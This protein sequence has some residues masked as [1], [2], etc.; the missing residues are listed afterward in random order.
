MKDIK[1]STIKKAYGGLLIGF[2]TVYSFIYYFA[3]A[4]VVN[5]YKEIGVTTLPTLVN[6]AL[7]FRIGIVAIVLISFAALGGL[8]IRSQKGHKNA[9][10]EKLFPV[11]A[12]VTTIATFLLVGLL[13]FGIYSP[14]YQLVDTL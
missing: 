11:I 7:R 8:I 9:K 14:L 12:I 10:F 1:P 3:S 5:L 2:A 6:I 4:S 13:V